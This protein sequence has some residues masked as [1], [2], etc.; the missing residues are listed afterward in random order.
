MPGLTV[1]VMETNGAQYYRNWRTMER[2]HPRAGAPWTRE[3]GGFF[4]LDESFYAESGGIFAESGHYAAQV[5]APD[6]KE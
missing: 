1:P 5:V 6:V 2:H 4:E 3:Q